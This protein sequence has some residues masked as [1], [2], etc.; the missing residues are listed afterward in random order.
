MTNFFESVQSSSPTARPI[1]V[2]GNAEPRKFLPAFKEMTT[3]DDANKNT[4]QPL[5]KSSLLKAL[6]LYYG[7]IKGSFSLFLVFVWMRL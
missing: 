7:T 5:S 1:F 3:C 2:M 4:F 6:Y